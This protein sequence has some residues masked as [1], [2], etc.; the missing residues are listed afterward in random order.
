MVS[1]GTGSSLG[2]ILDYGLTVAWPLG[3]QAWPLLPS[4][5]TCPS[6]FTQQWHPAPAQGSGG[7]V[8]AM[9]PNLPFPGASS[10]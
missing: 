4:V 1:S 6:L 2:A 5:F 10:I 9:P 7:S 3:P 8:L